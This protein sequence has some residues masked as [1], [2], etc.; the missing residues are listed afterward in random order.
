MQILTQINIM[1]TSSKSSQPLTQKQHLAIRCANL[2]TFNVA[3]LVIGIIAFIRSNSN[4]GMIVYNETQE[5]AQYPLAEVRDYNYSVANQTWGC[6]DDNY[7]LVTVKFPGTRTICYKDGGYN[8]QECPR[9]SGGKRIEGVPPT[10]LDRINNVSVCIK[11]NRA[12]GNYHDLANQRSLNIC[13]KW[14]GSFNNTAKKFCLPLTNLTCPLNQIQ[15]DQKPT[16]FNATSNTT[17]KLFAQNWTITQLSSNATSNPLVNLYIGLSRPCGI[18]DKRYAN[19]EVDV[20]DIY[21]IDPSDCPFNV[22]KNQENLLYSTTGAFQQKELDLYVQ[23]DFLNTI[24]R[25]VPDFYQESLTRNSYRLF[26]KPYS[27]WSISCQQQ[28]PTTQVARQGELFQGMQQKYL[29]IFILSISAYVVNAFYAVMVLIMYYKQ[30]E[31][32]MYVT[33]I[34]GFIIETAFYVALIVMYSMVINTITQIDFEALKYF[35]T[36]SCS[37]GPL[38][39]AFLSLD[40]DFTLDF[41]ITGLGLAFVCACL[42]IHLVRSLCPQRIRR[43]ILEVI[44]CILCRRQAKGK[45][46]GVHDLM[47][48]YYPQTQATAAKMGQYMLRK[49][50]KKAQ[51]EGNTT[52]QLPGLQ[53]DPTIEASRITNNATSAFRGYG[54]DE[55]AALNDLAE[56]EGLKVTVK[57][58]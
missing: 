29:V 4:Y 20:P 17:S 10:E 41:R 8:I 36:H 45:V 28:Y 12:I 43:E 38:Q 19:R 14:C 55:S 44:S 34:I 57:A 49:V 25:Q 54:N 24:Q 37:D 6:P 16:T 30:Q 58:V 56:G 47:P 15:L 26:Q 2:L 18:V 21:D 7:E 11:R 5:W 52:L 22:D 1:G 51:Q 35:A 53:N 48:E 23:N 46:M 27:T 39:S 33:H 32:V 13:P 40:A 50:L 9:K 3:L 42:L 31:C